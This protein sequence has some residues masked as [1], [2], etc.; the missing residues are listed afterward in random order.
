M[1]NLVS[2]KIG[3]F[4]AINVYNNQSTTDII[5]DL[6]GYYVVDGSAGGSGVTGS[7]SSVNS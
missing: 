6:A 5:G 2:V 3:A 4:G 1:P 7:L